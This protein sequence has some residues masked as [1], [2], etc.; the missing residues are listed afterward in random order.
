MTDIDAVIAEAKRYVGVMEKPLGSNR[1]LEV[2]YWLKEAGVPLGLPWCAA[3][4]GQ[5][6][7]QAL[8]ARW[9]LPRTALVGALHQWAVL[10]NVCNSTPQPGDLFLM[11]EPD[12]FHHTG[13]VTA[14]DADGA[15]YA[16]I[17]GNTND[18][19]SRE[20]VGVFARR[21]ARVLPDR[22]VRWAE[23]AA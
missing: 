8:G 5:V 15:H 14:V 10:R 13:L 20:G 19:G 21:R 16:T 4:M 9:P 12:G 22:Y 11:W 3:F 17:E 23:V 2:D 6:G 7:R 18:D 1:G